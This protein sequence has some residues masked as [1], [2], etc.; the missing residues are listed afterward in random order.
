MNLIDALGGV[1][2]DHAVCTTYSF[3][4]LFF[5]NF[6]I[7]PLQKAGVA[8]P[9]V[10]MDDQQYETLAEEQ[11][12]ASR[13]IGKHYYLEP[14]TVESTFHPKV[15]FLAGE[16]ACHVSVSSANLTLA[17]YTTAAQL[18]QTLT[19][20]ADPD[21][22]SEQ[23]TPAEIAVAQDVRVF[24]S[25]LANKYTSGRDVRTELTRAIEKTA[26]LEDR[27]RPQSERSGFVQN[28]EEPILTQ[29]LSRI[30]DVD[31]VTLFAPFF[32]SK[33][34][35]RELT[36]RINADEY[37]IL[38]SEGNTHLNP[39]AAVQAF[40]DAVTFNPIVHDTKRWIH[41]KGAV[42]HGNW[43]TATL[44][45][46]PNMTGQALL[47]TAAT[48][49]LEAGLLHYNPDTLSSDLWEQSTFDAQIGDE[50]DPGGLTFADYSYTSDSTERPSLTLSDVRVER[51]EDESILARF[52][53]PQIEDKTTV[54]VEHTEASVIEF[55]WDEN[56]EDEDNGTVTRLPESLA[57]SIVRLRLPDGRRTNYRQITTPPTEGTRD[58]GNVLR[59]DGRDGVQSLVDETLFF[60]VDIAPSV[61]TEAVSR[62]SERYKKQEVSSPEGLPGT[63]EDDNDNPAL[64]TGVS[65]VSNTSRKP[66]LGIK[67]AMDYAEE[68]IKTILKQPPTAASVAE[69]F[70]HFENLWYY[71]TQG[72]IRS[73]LGSQIRDNDDNRITETNLNV[74]RLYSICVNRISTIFDKKY[75]SRINAHIN[76]VHSIQPEKLADELD[77]KSVADIFII[78]PGTVL[79][80][81]EWHDTAFI[82]R[83]ELL[84]NY[85]LGMTTANPL[86][87]E[88]LL[89]GDLITER[90]QEYKTHL[91][92]QL[93]AFGD[94]VG[95]ELSLPG[96]ITPG[97]ELLF[98]GF[99]FRELARD[100]GEKL[101]NNKNI[102]DHYDRASFIEVAQLALAGN[103]RVQNSDKYA[104]L[105]KGNFDPVIRQLNGQS[106]PVP[107]L[108]SIIDAGT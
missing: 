50:E 34:T 78:Y 80:L 83:F 64:S 104:G 48:G 45:G 19:I 17:E 9:I 35:L 108:Q 3:E 62:L 90:L 65:G 87:G 57:Q 2:A 107:Q 72:L 26:W 73:S 77:K 95:A 74:S 70:D 8:T 84:R 44:Y 23:A 21:T 40:D 92:E 38:V 55:V 33:S 97:L 37:R 7:N 49:N 53:A 100:T 36:T 102:F 32:G 51:S 75:L 52:V 91:T 12:L 5:S 71:T 96:E 106:D 98:Y 30:G 58:M 27:S 69:L 105:K 11:E 13:A 81:M 76:Q 43:G 29:V 101:L 1:Q 67:D 93:S 82:N 20:D 47:E 22:A 94:R 86:I 15:A 99:W 63:P 103:D 68:R 61:L 14:I 85:H 6:A 39:D 66:H 59:N 60:D 41:A 56:S 25:R 88:Q 31:T 42:F 16:S 79:A 10:L 54:T 24:I 4:P 46:S 28:L 89:D 18:G